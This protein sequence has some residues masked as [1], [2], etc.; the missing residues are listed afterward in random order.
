VD[1]KR[2]IVRILQ[3]AVILVIFYFLLKGLVSN[4][5][6]VREYEWEFDYWL[7]G[8]SSVLIISLYLLWVEIWRRILKRGGNILSFKK[9]FKIWFVSNL[10][11]YLPGKVWSFLGMMYL[12]EK[13]GVAKGKGLSVAI[14]AQALSVLSGLLVAL[15]FLRYSYYQRFFAKTPAMTVVILLLIM[16]IVVLVFYPKLLEGIINLALRTFKK[17][18]IS[19]NF[20]PQDMLF[21]ISLYSGSWFLFGF[22]F[23]VFIKSITPVSLDI[24]LSLTGAF[25]GSFTLGFLAV[26][27]PGGIGVREGI[28]VV[29]L[30]NFFP[31]PVA[32]LISLVSRVWITLAEVLC[33]CVALALK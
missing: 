32:T 31:T 13:E 6:Q 25:A 8:I 10:G 29:L 24:Y 2:I 22:I 20:K 28:L 27:A 18:E 15:L 30:S 9:M 23:W 26:F 12:L 19:L 7:L 16:G 14:L 17:E 33:S 1:T 3:I 4:W 11:R 21:Y 5:N